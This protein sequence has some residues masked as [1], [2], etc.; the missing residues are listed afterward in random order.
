ME[1]FRGL[2]HGH[3]LVTPKGKRSANLCP[4][5]RHWQSHLIK[6][7]P[8]WSCNQ[9]PSDQR[10]RKV[11]VFGNFKQ[12][13]VRW[14]SDVKWVGATFGFSQLRREPLKWLG[15]ES[16]IVSWIW[17]LASL[18]VSFQ[19]L[20]VIWCRVSKRLPAHIPL[21]ASLFNARL[22]RAY[23]VIMRVWPTA[24]YLLS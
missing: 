1:V 18:V 16:T 14:C 15:V 13:W 19:L 24:V 12:Q 3:F 7:H 11:N 2:F 9:Q 8:H 10:P 5:R 4:V 6:G 17:S 23:S 21:I 20:V 22:L